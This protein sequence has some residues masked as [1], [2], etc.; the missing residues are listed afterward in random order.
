MREF[1]FFR[2][3]AICFQSKK[4]AR[5][6]KMD[7]NEPSAMKL[8]DI[9]HS[10]IALKIADEKTEKTLHLSPVMLSYW[11]HYFETRYKPG[12]D[13]TPETLRVE[14][15]EVMEALFHV[16]YGDVGTMRGWHDKNWE[17]FRIALTTCDMLQISD[18]ISDGIIK[19]ARKN[20]GLFKDALDCRACLEDLSRMK[21]TSL[22]QCKNFG[23]FIVDV[24]EELLKIE[25]NP[26]ERIKFIPNSLRVDYLWYLVGPKDC[27]YREY[28]LKQI[29]EDLRE[30]KD[31]RQAEPYLA[32]IIPRNH[33]DFTGHS[34]TTT[35][36]LLDLLA[37]IKGD[38]LSNSLILRTRDALALRLRGGFGWGRDKKEKE[39][40]KRDE[41]EV[42]D[43]DEFLKDF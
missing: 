42:E 43:E 36:D 34:R 15:V 18:T 3:N 16:C 24:F 10:S 33:I 30:M 22:K 39:K 1:F 11:S 5:I 4:N 28:A 26:D 40:R 12:S 29:I 19:H 37:E 41:Y 17:W 8:F 23:M 13:W 9:A 14:S 27:E 7:D 25:N 31:E 21:E 6:K 35:S 38:E 20:A 2:N 32:K